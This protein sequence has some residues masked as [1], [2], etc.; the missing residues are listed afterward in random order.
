MISSYWPSNKLKKFIKF[1]LISINYY[2]KAINNY[3]K[4]IHMMFSSTVN[5]I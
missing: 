2:S 1:K 5:I 3:A 4:I